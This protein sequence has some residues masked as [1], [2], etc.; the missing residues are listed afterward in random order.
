VLRV[1]RNVSTPTIEEWG[2]G[3]GGGGGQEDDEE[4]QKERWGGENVQRVLHVFGRKRCLVGAVGISRQ[5]CGGVRRGL[6]QTNDKNKKNKRQ[7]QV[8]EYYGVEYCDDW[9]CCNGGDLHQI[10]T[11]TS[12]R[13]EGIAPAVKTAEVEGKILVPKGCL[14][15][16]QAVRKV[17]ESD[18]R[19]T[20]IVVGEG[21]QVHTLSKFLGTPG[22]SLFVY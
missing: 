6:K 18:G 12:E 8:V 10:K 7:K 9:G 21:V 1:S 14:T 13:L 3:G 17:E 19:L 16:N 15:L 11:M 5:K 2:R 22:N 20:T 4:A